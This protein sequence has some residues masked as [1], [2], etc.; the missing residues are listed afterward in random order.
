MKTLWSVVCRSSDRAIARSAP[1]GSGP[2]VPVAI[3][4]GGNSG[5]GRA[6]TVALARDG[7]DIGLT[8][9]E[10]EAN[11]AEVVA[12]LQGHGVRVAH[13]QADFSRVPGADAVI[14]QLADELGGVDA[15]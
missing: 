10:D 8:W 4:T 5:I 13:R 3:V 12:E 6:C 7:F 2:F 14:D 15:F 11:L 9:H 1:L